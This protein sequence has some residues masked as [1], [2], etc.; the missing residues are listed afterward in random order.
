MRVWLAKIILGFVIRYL[1]KRLGIVSVTQH[2][3]A[4]VIKAT[5]LARENNPPPSEARNPNKQ[6]H[7]E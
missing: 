2:I 7:F 6:H 4:E 5:P 1:M 3:E